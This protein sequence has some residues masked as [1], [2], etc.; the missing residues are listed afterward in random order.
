VARNSLDVARIR[1]DDVIPACRGPY[2]HRDVD[3]VVD[4]GSTAHFPD[5]LGEA[6]VNG[7]DD[8]SS[9]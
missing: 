9:K 2:D 7:L 8:A 1:R 3:H 6:L 4:S 5:A